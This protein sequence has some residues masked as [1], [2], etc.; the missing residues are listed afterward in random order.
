MFHYYV[1]VVFM[2]QCGRLGDFVCTDMFIIA[3][4][5]VAFLRGIDIK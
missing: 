2:D 5:I 1:R 4:L 3:V